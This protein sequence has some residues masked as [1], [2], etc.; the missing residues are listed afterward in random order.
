MKQIK[1]EIVLYVP[2]NQENTEELKN[3]ILGNLDNEI[4]LTYTESE[5]K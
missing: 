1:I 5:I 4:L 2:D 3:I